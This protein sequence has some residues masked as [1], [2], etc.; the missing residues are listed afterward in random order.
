VGSSGTDGQSNID[1]ALK[2]FVEAAGE[3][4]IR[5]V[6]LDPASDAYRDIHET[7]WRLLRDRHL[8]RQLFLQ[9][10][11]L[12]GDGWR[13]ALELTKQNE[14]N[15]TQVSLGRICTILRAAVRASSG[16]DGTALVRTEDVA[17]ETGLACGFIAN[18]IEGELIDHWL[19]RH[20]AAWMDG[21]EGRMILVPPNFG[22]AKL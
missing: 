7:T 3:Q 19:N 8:I 13:T 5:V 1:I 16:G 4:W 11:A 2:L 6:L 21:L 12:T 9:R 14:N 10:F 18:V 22:L 20:G 15:D 17:A